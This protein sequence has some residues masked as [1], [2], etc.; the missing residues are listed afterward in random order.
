[1]GN[2]LLNIDLER[3]RRAAPFP[4]TSASFHLGF[5]EEEMRFGE[6]ETWPEQII[7]LRARLKKNPTATKERFLLAQLLSGSEQ[8]ATAELIRVIAE[9]EAALRQS[10][11]NAELLLQL[12]ESLNLQKEYKKAETAMRKAAALAPSDWRVQVALGTALNNQM[13]ALFTDNTVLAAVREASLSGN[14][15]AAVA[16]LRSLFQG[17]DTTKKLEILRQHGKTVGDCFDRAA[18]LAPKHPIPRINQLGHRLFGSEEFW[19]LAPTFESMDTSTSTR[20]M[21]DHICSPEQFAALEMAL[22]YQPKSPKLITVI[23]FLKFLRNVLLPPSSEPIDFTSY[24]R[25]SPETKETIEQSIRRVRSFAGSSDRSLRSRALQSLATLHYLQQD[26]TAAEKYMQDAQ[27]IG[28]LGQ[29][30]VNL[31]TIVYLQSKRVDKAEAFLASVL[32]THPDRKNYQTLAAIQFEHGR[33]IEGRKTLVAA[34]RRYPDHAYCRLAMLTCAIR[35]NQPAQIRESL[36]ALSKYPVDGEF[37][38]HALL[39]RGFVD[40]LEGRVD[41]A[42]TTFQRYP[43]DEAA[44]EALAAL[45]T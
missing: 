38:N 14:K 45:S 33:L 30:A 25:L 12:G 20:W 23:A 43:D 39:L 17:S 34:L 19:K 36:S 44:K 7:Q 42:R 18:A 11:R 9:T 21:A 5:S 26:L 1:M 40:A 16:A 3:L 28:R 2:L 15:E 4:S 10:P 32:S 29:S 27:K 24:E 13:M 31:L 8:D 41:K 6:N 37:L 22:P 35:E